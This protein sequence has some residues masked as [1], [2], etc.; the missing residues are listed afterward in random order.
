M[1]V[2]NVRMYMYV[3]M[4]VSMYGMHALMCMNARNTGGFLLKKI[5]RI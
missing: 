3:C 1:Y 4:Y 2:C 5:L